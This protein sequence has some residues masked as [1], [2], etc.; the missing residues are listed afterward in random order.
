MGR[1]ARR[2][3]DGGWGLLKFSSESFCFSIKWE[4][5]SLTK[6]EDNGRSVE[7]LKSGNEV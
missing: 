1:D 3:V 5:K 6:S 7:D 2:Q 4:A